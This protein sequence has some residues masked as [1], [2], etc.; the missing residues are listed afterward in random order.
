MNEFTF[1]LSCTLATTEMEKK[2]HNVLYISY[3]KMASTEIKFR[4]DQY[5]I[6]GRGTDYT[7]NEPI[8]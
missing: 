3:V 2:I 7:A 6:S 1:S 8:R 4:I 5:N